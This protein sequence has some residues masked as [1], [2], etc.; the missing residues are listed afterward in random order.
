[1]RKSRRKSWSASLLIVLG[2]LSTAPAKANGF[3]LKSLL[4]LADWIDLGISYNTEPMAVIMGGKDPSA[5]S[6][7]QFVAIDL[8]FSTGFKKKPSEWQEIDHWMLNF[9]VSQLN[10]NINFQEKIGAAFAPQA[11]ASPVG[12]WLTEAHISR[13]PGESRWSMQAGIMSINNNLLAIE[14][15]NFYNTSTIN[16]NYNV[17]NTGFPINPIITAGLQFAL[18]D[19]QWGELR[20]GYFDLD[21]ENEISSWLGVDL[22]QPKLGGSYQGL[23]WTVDLQQ[24]WTALSHDI[25][26]SGG[27]NTIPRLLP[28]PSG[29][30]GGYIADVNIQ[31]NEQIKL[32]NGDGLSRGV[33]LATTLAIDLPIG[34]DNRIWAAGAFALDDNNPTPTYFALGLLSQGVVSAREEDVLALG[35]SRTSMPWSQGYVPPL[36]TYEGVIELNYTIQVNENIQFQPQMQWIINPGGGNGGA[37]GNANTPGI[38]AAGITINLAI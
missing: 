7:F 11:S 16:N 2:C 19:H 15:Y 18:H 13:E 35:F 36:P 4:G 17:N 1:M 27:D 8:D 3:Q 33:Y 34:L 6:F 25:P 37:G 14:A 23:Q 5:N 20:Y 32:Q 31:G 10:G 21:Q 24:S 9:E 29:Q 12:T 28:S 22:A 38:W 30:L 26:I